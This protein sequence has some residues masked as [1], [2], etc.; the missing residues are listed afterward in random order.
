LSALWQQFGHAVRDCALQGT[1]LLFAEKEYFDDVREDK[2][3]HQEH[4]KK[5]TSAPDNK[6][7]A[8]CCLT[9]SSTVVSIAQGGG[10]ATSS[11]SV[12]NAPIVTDAQLRESMRPLASS[13]ERT[14]RQKREKEL[15]RAMDL[16]INAND[17]GTGCRRKVFDVQFDNKSAGE[18]SSFKC[19]I[20]CINKLKFCRFESP[21]M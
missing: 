15:D 9:D 4:K 14:S 20:Q 5:A 10:Q 17:R 21:Y 11:D 8:K 7:A 3:K 16:L 12:G 13:M 18:T 2:R 1:A 6:P 19:S